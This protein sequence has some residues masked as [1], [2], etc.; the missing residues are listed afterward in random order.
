[1]Q[2]WWHGASNKQ[3]NQKKHRAVPVAS[4]LQSSVKTLRPLL[5]AAAAVLLR[6]LAI[7]GLNHASKQAP[8]IVYSSFS[9]FI[10]MLS[11]K[12]AYAPYYSAFIFIIQCTKLL[13]VGQ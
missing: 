11:F 3:R 5:A 12:K 2:W 8:S 7:G 9:L 1:M 13:V 10:L 4:H 6:L